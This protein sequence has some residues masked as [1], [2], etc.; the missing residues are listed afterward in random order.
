MNKKSGIIN[1]II[2]VASVI[3]LMAYII[4]VD[5]LD[6]I[7]NAFSNCKPVWLLG[8]V[9]VMVGYWFLE[10]HTLNQGLKIFNKKLNL[11]YSAKNCMIG[12][13]FNSI[14]P[15]ATGGQPVQVYYMKKC[16]IEYGFATGALL[17]KF[18]S[19]QIS[20]T[21]ICL[22]VMFFKFN[23][24]AREIQG[25]SALMLIGFAINTFVAVILL[26]IAFNKKIALIIVNFFVKILGKLRI[27][28]DVDEKLEFVNKEV[29][30]FSEGFST[31]IENKMVVAKMF[32][33]STVQ[34]L[35]FYL[36]NI[37]IAFA[38]GVKMDLASIF[39]IIAGAACIQM[40]S[41]FV[42]LPGA[43]GGAELSYY[44]IYGSVFESW[45]ISAAVLLWRIYTFY[46]PIVVGLFFS[47]DLFGKKVDENT[48][49]N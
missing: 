26:L 45:Q 24:F 10:A 39:H 47:K 3:F 49:S 16:G 6:K 5:G 9:L 13:F 20:L 46:M 1:G 17:L 19:F 21:V 35:L 18:I 7:L 33:Y 44:V 14:T 23:E 37:V 11:K 28:K 40:S 25:F 8:G 41:T 36:V 2:I 27:F 34:I 48:F 22:F 42:P 30:L 38:L 29:D 15:S 32:L 4:F 12:Q 43:A 31:A